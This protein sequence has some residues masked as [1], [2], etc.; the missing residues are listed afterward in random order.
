MKEKKPSQKSTSRHKNSKSPNESAQEAA[1]R[2]AFS[3][4][5]ILPHSSRKVSLGP[6]TNR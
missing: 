1:E 5:S 4:G 6:N 3:T 2:E